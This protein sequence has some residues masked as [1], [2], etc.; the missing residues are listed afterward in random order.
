MRSIIALCF[1]FVTV[2]AGEFDA[3]QWK[4]TFSDEFEGDA[5][6]KKKWNPVDPWGKVRNDEL[7]GYVPNAFI[8][9]EGR[10]SVVG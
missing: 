3:N 2:S 1:V 9:K 8:V 4:L 5:L 7:Q 10:N 6:D